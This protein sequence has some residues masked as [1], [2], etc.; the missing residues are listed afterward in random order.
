MGSRTEL[1]TLLETL[2]GSSNVYFQPPSGFLL[3][4]PCIT[5]FRNDIDTKYADNAPYSLTKEYSITVIDADPD[6]D[7]PDKIAAL[8]RSRFD[9]SF[10]AGD[11]N[12]DVFTLYF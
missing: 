1:Q 10:K 3:A 8:P 4:Y 6:S 11:L 12:H 7:I 9:R 2:L 5:Y